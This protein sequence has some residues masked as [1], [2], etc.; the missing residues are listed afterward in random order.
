MMAV[1]AVMAINSTRARVRKQCSVQTIV[2]SM[3]AAQKPTRCHVLTCSVAPLELARTSARTQDQLDV[4][5]FGLDSEQPCC[6]TTLLI[7]SG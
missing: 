7:P 2:L 1:M 3:H 5:A 6:Y 4:S